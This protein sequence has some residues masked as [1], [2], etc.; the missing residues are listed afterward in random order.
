MDDET[1]FSLVRSFIVIRDAFRIM[2]RDQVAFL[3][4]E[5]SRH[6]RVYHNKNMSLQKTEADR[7]KMRNSVGP[8]VYIRVNITNIKRNPKCDT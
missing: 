2:R 6:D 4:I 3:R 7:E 8:T 5:E 1:S